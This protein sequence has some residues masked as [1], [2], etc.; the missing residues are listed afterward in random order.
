MKKQVFGE[1][2]D[3]TSSYILVAFMC[4]CMAFAVYYD[5]GLILDSG[6]IWILLLG[7]LSSTADTLMRLIYQKYLNT[8]RELIDQGVLEPEN[9]VFKDH[10]QVSSLTVFIGETMGIGGIL[11]SVILLAT[12]FHALDLVLFYCFIYYFGSGLLMSLKYIV[13]AIKRSKAPK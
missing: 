12:I 6:C 5:G 10:N 8:E 9:D 11:P 1:F 4:T 13:K 3:A 7:S 2:A